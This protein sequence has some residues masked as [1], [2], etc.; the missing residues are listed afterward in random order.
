MTALDT[1]D[2]QWTLVTFGVGALERAQAFRH[3]SALPMT[4]RPASVPKSGLLP[5]ASCV[6]NSFANAMALHRHRTLCHW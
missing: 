2:I 4:Q 1:V 6:M 5:L 3:V